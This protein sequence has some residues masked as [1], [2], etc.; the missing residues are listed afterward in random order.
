MTGGKE[1]RDFQNLQGYTVINTEI[2]YYSL[3]LDSQQLR[4]VP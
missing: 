4:T 1:F 3:E 2:H